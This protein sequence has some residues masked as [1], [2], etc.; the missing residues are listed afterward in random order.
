MESESG[1]YPQH[2]A[3]V[4][5]EARLAIGRAEG[6]LAGR[7]S[8]AI[9]LVEDCSTSP[10]SSSAA[11][12]RRDTFE[13]LNFAP[14]TRSDGPQALRRRRGNGHTHDATAL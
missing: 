2:H 14:Q 8:V 9:R 4:R 13:P 12:A 6:R 5:A 3:G 11:D 1:P 7:P 10:R